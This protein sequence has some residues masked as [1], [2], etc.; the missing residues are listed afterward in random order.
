MFAIL[1]ILIDIRQLR[2][3]SIVAS[4]Q[5]DG[6]KP[7]IAMVMV[8]VAEEIMPTSANVTRAMRGTARLLVVLLG[9]RGSASQRSI[10]SPMMFM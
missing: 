6:G 2:W 8:Y 3:S 5:V 1:Y 4:D 9:R 10:I 7:Q